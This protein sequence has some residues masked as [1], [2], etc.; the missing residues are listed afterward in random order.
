MILALNHCSKVYVYTS[1][2]KNIKQAYHERISLSAAGFWRAQDITWDPI[3]RIGKR[4]NYYCYGTA[5]AEVEIDL[6]TGEHQTRSAEVVMDV[7]RSL[8]PAVDIGS[9]TSRLV[10]YEYDVL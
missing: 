8:N 1:T 5:A 2:A 6:L 3:S 10:H 7:G 9:G 4:W